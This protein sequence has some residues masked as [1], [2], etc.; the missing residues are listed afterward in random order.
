MILRIV[1]IWLVTLLLAAGLLINNVY[2]TNRLAEAFEDEASKGAWEDFP[3]RLMLSFAII[4]FVFGLLFLL[5][6]FFRVNR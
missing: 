4:T 6:V 2:R 3:G 1:G 5:G